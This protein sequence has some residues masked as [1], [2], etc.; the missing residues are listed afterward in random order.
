[1]SAKINGVDVRTLAALAGELDS[2]PDR[3]KELASYTRSVRVR[4]T[5]GY[6]SHARARGTPPHGY[7]EP[8]W[9]GGADAAM[10]ASEAL[11]GAV[12]GCIATG[13]AANAALREV[14]IREL[15][16]EVE[17]EIDV[18]A[19]LGLR[20]SHSG[21]KRLRVRIHAAA[22]ADP[23]LL[24]EIAFRAVQ[25]SPVVNTVRNPAQVEYELERLD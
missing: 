6:Q 21:Y 11:L 23:A 12:G 22:D 18:P 4:W 17:G 16:I 9:L 1:M 20:D 24:E 15:E 13:F 2:N 7:D 5:S 10:A 3:A 19:F 14:E 25:L 8:R